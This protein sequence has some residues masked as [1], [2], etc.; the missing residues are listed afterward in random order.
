MPF[1]K[2][3]AF[4]KSEE[5]PV[6][7]LP[8]GPEPRDPDPGSGTWG[9][10]SRAGPRLGLW[11]RALGLVHSNSSKN[12]RDSSHSIC[13]SSIKTATENSNSSNIRNQICHTFTFKHQ[14]SYMIGIQVK[15]HGL[16]WPSQPSCAGRLHQQGRARLK[17]KTSEMNELPCSCPLSL[18]TSCLLISYDY[19]LRGGLRRFEPASKSSK[20]STQSKQSQQ[21]KPC[22][23]SKQSRARLID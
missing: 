2:I 22:K 1:I 7:D 19:A 14:C 13:C 4:I 8:P 3:L 5:Q 18:R 9:P 12:R 11:A 15:T 20:P 16:S 23:T 17:I 10:R 6:S 21:S